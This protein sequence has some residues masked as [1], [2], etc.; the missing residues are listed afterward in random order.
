MKL[1][2]QM[3]SFVT[4]KHLSYKN[5]LRIAFMVSVIKQFPSRLHISFPCELLCPA[6]SHV[7]LT[8]HIFYESDVIKFLNLC[9]SIK[10]S[11]SQDIHLCQQFTKNAKR[12]GKPLQLP[13]LSAIN[14]LCFMV[15]CK[16]L[17]T[18]KLQLVFRMNDFLV[19]YIKST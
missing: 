15:C 7:S 9:H 4:R 11:H 6:P 14:D 16:E 1:R 2:D 17:F 19:I 13:H 5:S 3:A 8:I 12:I 10:A 18:T